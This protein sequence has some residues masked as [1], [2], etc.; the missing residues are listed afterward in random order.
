MAALVD[1]YPQSLLKRHGLS[2]SPV[3]NISAVGNEST[4][5]DW[6]PDAKL[7]EQ[8]AA[9]L[10]SQLERGSEQLPKDWP[11]QLK[12]SLAW[13]GSELKDEE[14]TYTLSHAEVQ[15][16][17]RALHDIIGKVKFDVTN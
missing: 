10:S 11:T 13:T 2:S 8:R 17:E 9:E 3:H 5:I 1:F 16:V 12:G 6:V 14:Y 7:F 15:E 4:R